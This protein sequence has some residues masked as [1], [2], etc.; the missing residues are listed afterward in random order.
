MMRIEM[1]PAA[2]GD[3]L[4][5]EYGKESSPRRILIDAGLAKTYKE[6]LK[7]RLES[8]GG[9]VELELLVV[10]HIDRDH[11]CGILPLLRADPCL[12][13]PSDIWFNGYHH[14]SD[15]LGPK[16]GEALGKLLRSSELPWNVAFDTN[17]VVVPDDGP[18][19]VVDLAGGARLTLLS[20]RRRKLVEL[21][22]FW[23]DELGGWG[24]DVDEESGETP[25]EP[26]DVLGKRPAIT[27]IS[28]PEVE[29]YAA[30]KFT[31]DKTEPNGSSI[32]FLLEYG[33]KR[34]LF[35][36]DAHPT[37][38][39]DALER[40]RPGKKV[41]LDAF[42]ISHHGSE[43]NLSPDLLEKV[44][45]CRYL[46]S[47]NGDSFGHPHAQ[48]L[49]RLLVGGGEK[50][51]LYFN[52]ACDYTTVWDEPTVKKT[53]GYETVYPETGAGIVIEL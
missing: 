18:L 37:E 6:A 46:I 50:K 28:A 39:L 22:A 36:A 8:I 2:F 26:D 34:V 4:L 5:V 33:G 14:L 30:K 32:A 25:P 20:P 38:L 47:T 9:P 35:A 45:C 29:D 24:D 11:I 52:Y 17:A 27:S 12:V 23:D 48:T 15:D 43:A 31:E 16:D 44:D 53:Y 1:L 21:L 51:A 10:T 42:K 7:P 19:P 40:Y 41:R 13:S 49:C 3:C